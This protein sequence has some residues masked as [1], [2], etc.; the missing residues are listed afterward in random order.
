M[1]RVKAESGGQNHQFVLLQTAVAV[2]KC[3]LL[4]AEFKAFTSMKGGDLHRF[5]AVRRA[6]TLGPRIHHGS[7]ADGAWNAD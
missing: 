5:Q 6:A 7:S 1:A 2:I 4:A 3:Q